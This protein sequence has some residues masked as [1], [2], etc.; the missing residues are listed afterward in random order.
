MH[1]GNVDKSGQLVS[2]NESAREDIRWLY[3]IIENRPGTWANSRAE[4]MWRV[5]LNRDEIYSVVILAGRKRADRES[6]EVCELLQHD[7]YI[8]D[9]FFW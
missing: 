3:R 9:A 5:G 6:R 1:A 2:G 8:I 4:W 7:A